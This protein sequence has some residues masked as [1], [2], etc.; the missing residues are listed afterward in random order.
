MIELELWELILW[1]VIDVLLGMYI[2]KNQTRKCGRK[3]SREA[4]ARRVYIGYTPT[5]EGLG[6]PPPKE[7]CLAKNKQWRVNL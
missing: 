3:Y 4:P 1:T 2:G 7:S 6:T 5:K